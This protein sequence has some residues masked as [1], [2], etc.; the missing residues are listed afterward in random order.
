MEPRALLGGRAS[1]RATELATGR[2][3]GAG[4]EVAQLGSQVVIG[5]DDECFEFVDR[6]G[7]S[8]HC[9]CSI[10]VC[11]R[12][13]SRW[14]SWARG[15]SAGRVPGHLEAAGSLVQLAEPSIAQTRSPGVVCQSAHATARA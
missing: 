1:C 11:T 9:S 5:G 13:A 3:Q 8:P 10:S 4:G 14:P 2:Y 12:R 6:C 15:C 7:P